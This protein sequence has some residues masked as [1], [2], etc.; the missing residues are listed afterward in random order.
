[1]YGDVWATTTLQRSRVWLSLAWGSLGILQGVHPGLQLD[2]D[3]PEHLFDI[4]CPSGQ[5]PEGDL[6]VEGSDGTRHWQMLIALAWSPGLDQSLLSTRWISD[7][8]EAYMHH[9]T[10]RVWC[11]RL[12]AATILEE[13]FSTLN[14]ASLSPPAT[15]GM[16]WLNGSWSFG[17][18]QTSC[19][20]SQIPSSISRHLCKVI[21]LYLQ[22]PEDFY[23]G[24][25]YPLPSSSC[26][27]SHTHMIIFRTLVAVVISEPSSCCE[28]GLEVAKGD[29]SVPPSLVGSHLLGCTSTALVSHS[30]TCEWGV[31]GG[32]DSHQAT[33]EMRR[34][35]QALRVVDQ[36]RNN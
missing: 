35:T 36:L 32:I 12:E 14:L 31:K 9:Y 22:S 10:L 15:H 33:T 4:F 6:G 16:P 34:P 17:R 19:E 3:L 30:L 20:V 1:M 28:T 8:N 23:S 25:F 7:W 2:T 5:L 29:L 13:Q 11:L 21:E 27:L 18:S 26:S 24:F